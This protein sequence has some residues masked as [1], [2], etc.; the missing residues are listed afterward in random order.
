MKRLYLAAPLFNAS[1]QAFNERVAAILE[2]HFEV[3]LPQRDGGLVI[4]LI[5]KGIP[6]YQAKREIFDRDVAAIINA[7]VILAVLDGRAV[8][9]GVAVELGMAFAFG[10]LCWGLKTDTRSLAW[11]GD[12]PMIE[13]PLTRIFTTPKELADYLTSTK[14]SLDLH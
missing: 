5:Q 10:K 11:F 14:T 9:E 12:N 4:E 8:D 6:A 7:D 1:E 2:Q 13:V 3:F